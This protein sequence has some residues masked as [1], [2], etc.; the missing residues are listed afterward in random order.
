M[1]SWD[2]VQTHVTSDNDIHFALLPIGHRSSS[3]SEDKGSR[4]LKLL[5]ELG[6][7]RAHT[8]D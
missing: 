2:D 4:Y 1:H 6:P 8:G 7:E 3:V 5:N